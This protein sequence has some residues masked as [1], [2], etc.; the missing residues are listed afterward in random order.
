MSTCLTPEL[1]SPFKIA[2][3]ELAAFLTAAAGA[4]GSWESS[5][6]SEIWLETLGALD[7]PGSGLEHFFRSITIRAAARLADE[8]CA[9]TIV[10]ASLLQHSLEFTFSASR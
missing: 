4:G 6:A 7:W 9:G 5:R 10:P 3:Q 1:N 8:C 2:E